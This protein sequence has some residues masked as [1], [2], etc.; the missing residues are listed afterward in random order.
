MPAMLRAISIS[1]FEAVLRGEERA[2]STK[3]SRFF[4]RFSHLPKRPFRTR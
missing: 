3:I 2:K 4:P 1:E